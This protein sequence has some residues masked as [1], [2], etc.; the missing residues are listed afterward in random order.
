M[1]W[2]PCLQ[3]SQRKCY[4]NVRL[5]HLFCSLYKCANLYREDSKVR[6]PC[7]W[8]FGSQFKSP[9]TAQGHASSSTKGP[10]CPC[11]TCGT[12]AS[13]EVLQKMKRCSSLG[14]GCAL[15][16][17]WVRAEIACTDGR[18]Y[19]LEALCCTTSHFFK[20][21][22]IRKRGK[23]GQTWCEI[24]EMVLKT[25]ALS[26]CLKLC[27]ITFCTSPPCASIATQLTKASTQCWL[28]CFRS[29]CVMHAPC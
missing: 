14:E 26:K 4:V 17:C 1:H 2:T 6:N 15:H 22:C 12:I 11:C 20:A 27:W 21:G 5:G 24:K 23:R 10:Q 3:A 8:L 9:S 13:N 7:S 18:G 29:L 19:S 16:L 28:L 25:C